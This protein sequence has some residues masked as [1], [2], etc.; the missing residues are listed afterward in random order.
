[1][2]RTLRN[3]LFSAL[4]ALLLLGG[5]EGVLRVLGWPDPGLYAA[6]DQH[7]A[8]RHPASIRSLEVGGI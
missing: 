1:M 5:M 8:T 7:V 2:K 4:T 6:L 3:L